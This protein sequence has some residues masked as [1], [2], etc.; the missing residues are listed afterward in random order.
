MAARVASGSFSKR[1]VRKQGE[2]GQ[3]GGGQRR[4]LRPRAGGAVDRR[5]GQRAVD[6]HPRGQAR[7]EVGETETEQ[8][9]IRID[10]VPLA[11]GVGLGRTE[12]LGEPHQH[13]TYS[14]TEQVDELVTRD[15]GQAEGRQPAVDVADHGQS[16]VVE[17]E[18]PGDRDP[19]ERH[20]QGGREHRNQP[21]E[22]HES[23]EAD[24][25]DDQGQRVR[26]VEVGHDV[27]RLLEEVPAS[28][29]GAQEVRHLADHDG[30]REPDD[31]AF[32]HWLGDEGGQEAQPEQPGSQRHQ[33]G[34]QGQAGGQGHD[35]AGAA[36][37]GHHARRQGGG[38]GHRGDHEVPGRADDGV[39][40]ECRHGG[41]Q[42]DD[43]GYAG[44]GCVGQRLRD[45]HRPHGESGEHVAADPLAAE[46]HERRRERS[47]REPSSPKFA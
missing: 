7:A 21:S 26:L 4:H 47:R 38:R 30:E 12:A 28:L 32:E 35:V 45:Q 44:D 6:H 2:H 29:R 20:G 3:R 1:P 41:V 40:H 5:L 31:E 24:Q 27:P 37:R 13:H 36:D 8:L 15:V 11:G 43:R 19:A 9:T 17:P 16:V 23:R 18:E 14:G 42:P 33:P 10:V 39:Q 22:Q 46:T 34:G 25:P